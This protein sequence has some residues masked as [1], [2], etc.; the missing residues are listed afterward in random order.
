MKLNSLRRSGGFTLIEL[1]VVIA[2]IAVL[3]GL[4]LP[5]VQKVRESAARSTSS[6]NMR[7][8][9]IA[10]NDM[11]NTYAGKL[12]PSYTYG[13]GTFQGKM[14]SFFFFALPNIEQGNVYNSF[15]TGYTNT[16]NY[17]AP[18]A[19]A[20]AT[21]AL[22]AIKTYY[23]PLDNSNPGNNNQC[24]YWVNA[25]ALKPATAG[26]SYGAKF[27]ATF[28][29]KGT[30][31][32]II[33]GERYS[34]TADVAFY[35][36]DTFETTQTV[37][38][39][40][41]SSSAK[42]PANSIWGAGGGSTSL[43]GVNPGGMPGCVYATT[44]IMTANNIQIC[45]G[46]APAA[47]VTVASPYGDQTAHAYSAAGFLV[48]MADA[49]TRPMSTISTTPYAAYELNTTTNPYCSTI[50]NWACDP[51]TTTVTPSGF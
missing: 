8:M 33:F 28:N 4:L 32:I 38:T 29:Q 30:T 51:N 1:L 36:A 42:I 5:A 31:N 26:E 12:P 23:A 40:Y 7:Q 2:I 24:S 34:Q 17:H 45:N 49:S 13:T 3:I 35:W 50:F 6:N 19:G 47:P 44:P 46:T 20:S 43:V 22:T 41:S 25:A 15:T 39:P 37:T 10:L 11:G 27:P 18:A 48:T 9:G 14:G 21:A 16:A